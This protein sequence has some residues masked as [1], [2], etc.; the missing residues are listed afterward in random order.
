M[1][2]RCYYAV[3][4]VD[5]ACRIYLYNEINYFMKN[6]DMQE[7]KPIYLQQAN[8]SSNDEISLISLVTV[9][10]RRK[11]LISTIFI[12]FLLS[13]V[14]YALLTP[15]TYT[16]SVSIEVGSQMINGTVTPLE[17]PKALLAK[18][19]HSFFHQALSEHRK[20]RPDDK[21]KYKIIFSV[22]ADSNIT[23]LEVKGSDDETHTLKKLLQSISQKAIQDHSHIYGSIKRD[24]ETRLSQAISNLELLKKS[25]KN[26]S[27]I[28]NTQN[29]I[30]S[31]NSQLANLRNTR[32]IQP[33]IRSLEATGT[34]RKTIVIAAIV[35]GI[36]FSVFAAFFAEFWLK[37][38]ERIKEENEK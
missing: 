14:A 3:I 19:Q 2:S 8:Y 28:T 5:F 34:S 24:L 21:E 31:L 9:L 37:V 22:P 15:R 33:P 18:L 30:E 6:N 12:I 11:L 7:L 25:D 26:E 27:E 35:A 20:S 36:I 29:I 13:G 1:Q 38:Q 32:T 23:L 10:L 17:T 4:V 16:S